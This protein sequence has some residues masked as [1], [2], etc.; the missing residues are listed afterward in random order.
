MSEKPDELTPLRLRVLRAV[1]AGAALPGNGRIG[2]ISCA[3][4]LERRGYLIPLR[5]SVWA[6]TAKGLAALER[7]RRLPPGPGEE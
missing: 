7:E 3:R 2:I 1:R 5:S 4:G 6:L